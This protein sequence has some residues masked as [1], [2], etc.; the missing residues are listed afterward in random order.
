MLDGIIIF[1]AKYLYLL[2]IVVYLFYL[3]KVDKKIRLKLIKLTIFSFP[4]IWLIA[5]VSSFFISDPRPFVLEH[6]KPLIS[7]AADNGFPSD[8]T[9]LTMAIASVV[10]AY[11]RKLGA[12]LFFVAL[13]VGTSRI[14]ARIHHPLDI[15]GST[16]IAIGV[17]GIIFF[18]RRNTFVK[19]SN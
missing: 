8:H 13:L 3:W 14:L 1:S 16:G 10:F 19:N 6:I 18:A 7:H 15:V 17:T 4:L 11:N 2:S 5:K 9:L 12:F